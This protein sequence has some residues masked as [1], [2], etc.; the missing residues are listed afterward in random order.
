MKFTV[1]KS[2]LFELLSSIQSIVPSKP[3]LQIISNVMVEAREDGTLEVTATD[4][5]VSVRAALT[6]D[7][8]VD[9]PGRTT[10][11]VRKLV[12]ILRLAPEGEVQFDIDSDD[13]ARIVTGAAKY[14]VLGMDMREYPA[15]REPDEDSK[16][17][18]IDRAV[19]RE[20]LRKTAYAVGTDETRRILTGLLLRFADAKLTVVATDG[21][22]L[23]LV[24]Q[25]VEFPVDNSCEMIL[26]SKAV[27]LLQRLLTGDGPMTIYGQ[28]NQIVFDCGTFRFYSK[29]IEGVYAKYQ[30]VIPTKCDESITVNRKELM[31]AISCVDIMSGDK[32]RAVRLSFSE[33]ALN[34]SASNVESGEANAVLPIKYSGRALAASYNPAYI[35]DCLGALDTDTVTFEI[36]EGYTSAKILSE[37]IPFIYVIMPLRI[38]NA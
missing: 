21:K 17:F 32:I 6:A 19:F 29:L 5:D 3:A 14:R 12:E 22:R 37:K 10:L 31:D 2:R 34:L 8:K 20:M 11:P 23:A 26:P 15:I 7:V 25:E 27:Q 36:S 28:T 24:E 30:S 18:T 38:P 33:G 16:S 35:K 1:I 4:L 13:V 9:E